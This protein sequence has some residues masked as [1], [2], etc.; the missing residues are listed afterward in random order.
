[1]IRDAG[2]AI[3]AMWVA[4]VVF[5]IFE[6]TRAK[7]PARGSALPNIIRALVLIAIFVLLRIS[8]GMHLL[9]NLHGPIVSSPIVAITSAVVCALGIGLA[10]WARVYLGPNWGLPMSLREG[11]ELITTGPY[12]FVRHPIYTGILLALVGTAVVQARWPSIVMLVFFFA[13]FIYA[14]KVEERAMREQFP[15]EYPAYVRRTKML[16]PFVI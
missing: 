3:G 11:H 16:V 8:L 1:M 13:Y 12:A 10:I 7:R 9:R 15:A 4:F 6:A 5:W 2:L 14:A